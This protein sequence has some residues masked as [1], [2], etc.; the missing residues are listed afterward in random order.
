MNTLN[1]QPVSLGVVVAY[2]TVRLWSLLQYDSSC[3]VICNNISCRLWTGAVILLLLLVMKTDYPVSCIY[4]SVKCRYIT[5]RCHTVY[6]LYYCE[7][8]GV[9]LP[10]LK[11]ILRT[12]LPSVL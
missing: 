9:H 4:A 8:S 12:Y 11:P 6:L 1:V 10:G 3:Q 2:S 5:D 7:H